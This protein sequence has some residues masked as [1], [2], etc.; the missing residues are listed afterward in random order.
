VIQQLAQREHRRTREVTFEAPAAEVGTVLVEDLALTPGTVQ[1]PL[2]G[3]IPLRVKAIPA[4]G[5]A[6]AGWSGIDAE[7]PDAV[8]D[9]ARCTKVRARFS[10]EGGSGQDRL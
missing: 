7:G 4:K 6:F 3:G 1:L 2:L 8:I 10:R 5:W 9:P